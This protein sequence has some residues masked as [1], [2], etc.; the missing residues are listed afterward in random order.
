MTDLIARAT[1]T[2]PQASC[3]PPPRHYVSKERPELDAGA[4]HRYETN[5]L[6]VLRPRW[7][8]LRGFD[9]VLA[10]CAR[11]LPSKVPMAHAS[12]KCLHRGLVAPAP[13]LCQEA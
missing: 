13:V 5:T 6:G 1:T 7:L 8:S 10:V 2:C 3:N 9:G 11:L 12:T 4:D